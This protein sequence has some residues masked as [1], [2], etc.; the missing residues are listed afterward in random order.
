MR[1]HLRIDFDFSL[2][3]R[4]KLWTWK[5]EEKMKSLSG[6]Y[7]KAAPIRFCSVLFCF[8]FCLFFRF[9]LF[10]FVCLFFD[11][12]VFVCFCFVLFLCF[13]AGL[14]AKEQ[15]VSVLT[16][17]NQGTF[18]P[19]GAQGG[20]PRDPTVENHFPTGIL[21]WNL[22]HICMGYKNSQFCKKNLKMLYRFKMAAK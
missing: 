2:L 21:Q 15:G 4:T 14:H 17:S 1:S 18:T 11:L 10:L 7:I 9:V 6:L 13:F 20:S 5:K 16:L 22:H 12:I 19:V 8:L 3:L